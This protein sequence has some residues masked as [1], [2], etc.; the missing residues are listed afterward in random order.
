[1]PTGPK[2]PERKDIKHSINQMS[3]S[4]ATTT[5]AQKENFFDL[6]NLMSSRLQTMWEPIDWCMSIWLRMTNGTG[7]MC[8]KAMRIK[9][10]EQVL[11]SVILSLQAAGQ[12]I[13][14]GYRSHTSIQQSVSCMNNE[15]N[16]NIS[17]WN[18]QFRRRIVVTGVTHNNT[19][20]RI[21]RIGWN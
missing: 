5:V 12:L 4:S 13:I 21:E 15:T 14:R 18:R 9:T 11:T 1:M 8:G 7:R 19:E 16:I 10:N 3:P 17:H 2:I 20:N 6:Q